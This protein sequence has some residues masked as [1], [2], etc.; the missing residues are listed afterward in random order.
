MK[1][2]NRRRQRRGFT[3]MEVLL[4][5]AI[6]VIIGSLVSVG[7]MGIR[8]AKMKDGAKVQINAF[9]TALDVYYAAM[10]TYPQSL[11][12]LRQA[13]SDTDALKR[14]KDGGG[15]YLAED[16]P[17]DPWGNDYLYL[18][19]GQNDDVDVYTLGRDARPGG[20]GIDA[21]IGSWDLE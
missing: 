1:R 12:E 18:Y 15:P 13:P 3:L 16:I 21:T 14:W 6:L 20:E 9:K 2:S 11:Q 8:K 7:Y 4:V 17:K 5:M 19:P 10:N